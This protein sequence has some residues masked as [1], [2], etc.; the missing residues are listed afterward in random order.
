MDIYTSIQNTLAKKNINITVGNMYDMIEVWKSWYRGNVNDFHY[1]NMKLADGTTCECERLT[2]NM[3]KKVSEDFAKLLWSEKVQINLSTKKAT[4]QL[5]SILDNKKNNFSITFPQFIEKT[6]ALGTGAIIEYKEN[7]ETVIEYIDADLIIPYEYTNSYVNGM[8]TINQFVRNENNKK[9]YYTH[10]TYH[11]YTDGVYT[12]RN[13]LYKCGTANSLG[14]EI[15]FASLFPDVQNPVVYETDTP[16]FQ[17]LKPNIVN[18]FDLQSPMGISVYANQID[19]LKALDVKYDSFMN[20][21]EL[22]KKRILVDKT[23]IK[24]SLQAND[25]GTITN[26]SYFDK[27]DKVYQAINGMEAQPVKEID[28]KLR[29]QEHID[30]INAD[31]NYLSAGVGL[32]QDYYNF[33]SSGAKTATEVVSENSDTYRTKVHYQ[34]IIKDVV[35]DLIKSICFLEGITTADINIVFD[36]S[37]IE[38]E[39]AL[40][41]RGLKL[42]QAK[43]ISLET[44]MSKYL[45]YD[46]DQI[47]DEKEKMFSDLQNIIDMLDN[48]VIDKEKAITLLFGDTIDDS[49]KLRIIANAGEVSEPATPV[50][51]N[52]NNEDNNQEQNVNE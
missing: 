14:K 50:E 6:C 49:E 45:N 15:D 11:D 43:T 39:N 41:E 42:Y 17:I 46:D 9:V 37:I 24:S 33:T 18:N 4:K 29:H 30:S 32:G 23:A 34:I 8:I 35:Y 12:K 19:K 3:A 52:N 7:G 36:D 16:H 48:N 21:F 25:D 27:N 22:G 13:E 28:F 38:D 40:I 44:F 1:Y 2:M 10:L 51:E 31:L 26:V 20:E 5:W 47:A